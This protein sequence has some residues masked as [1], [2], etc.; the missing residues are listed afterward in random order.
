VKLANLF[1][2]I[3]LARRTAYAIY[4]ILHSD[5]PWIAQSAVRYCESVL[6]GSQVGL[7]WGSGRSTNWFGE[8]MK[9][10]VSIEFDSAWHERVC[11]QL[12]AKGHRHIEC[13]FI[14]LDHPLEEPA[15]PHY[16]PLPS[17]VKIAET[18]ADES[19]DFVVVDGHYRQACAL[20][21]LPKLKSGGHLL[22]D[23]SNWLTLEEW[24]VP[25]SWPIVHQ[26]SNVMTQTTIWKKP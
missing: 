14:A 20:A 3:Y 8:R 24:G 7:E 11:Q 15:Q 17:Y 26:G 13:K 2:P 9:S 4:E 6:D 18:F 19:L 23:N 22:I 16:D 1:R 21:A 25:A 5:E 10:L 12:N